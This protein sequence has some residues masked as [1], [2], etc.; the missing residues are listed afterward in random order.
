MVPP[1]AG[2]CTPP[3][4]A[5]DK[6]TRYVW[7]EAPDRMSAELLAFDMADTLSIESNAK[8]TRE[9]PQPGSR[10]A[11]PGRIVVGADMVT[12]IQTVEVIL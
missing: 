9:D 4:L 2:P 10:P 5:V 11:F 8:M 3:Y 1:E 6:F 7:V 12:F